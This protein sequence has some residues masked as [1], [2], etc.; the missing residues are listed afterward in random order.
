MQ[1]KCVH[2]T[3][4]T[5]SLSLRVIW[6]P[7]RKPCTPRRA[8]RKQEQAM[9]IALVLGNHV[10]SFARGR[11]PARASF[12]ARST[13]TPT[14]PSR[15]TSCPGRKSMPTSISYSPHRMA[16]SSSLKSTSSSTL[17]NH[18][19]AKRLECG[20]FANPSPSPISALK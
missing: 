7:T 18:N 12:A 6:Q 8:Y 11:V 1:F 5:Q 10:E 15:A 9:H 4:A 14:V 3:A 2:S 20:T 17:T 19:S 16:A 13:L